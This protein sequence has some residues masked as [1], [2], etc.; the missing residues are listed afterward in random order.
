MSSLFK[1]T[2]FRDQQKMKANFTIIFSYLRIRVGACLHCLQCLHFFLMHG[3]TE[4]LEILASQHQTDP[5]RRRKQA[6]CLFSHPK[7]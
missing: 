2:Y 6:R 1:T 3:G 4:N 5:H 7:S